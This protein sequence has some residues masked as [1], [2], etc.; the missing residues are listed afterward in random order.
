MN[1]CAGLGSKG[2]SAKASNIKTATCIPLPRKSGNNR[3]AA[4]Q[5]LRRAS[6]EF[7]CR[8]LWSEAGS[9][10]LPPSLESGSAIGEGSMCTKRQL[11]DARLSVISRCITSVKDGT[12]NMK[13]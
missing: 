6:E 2:L 4:V 8:A 5:G 7:S 13:D 9:R 12:Y 3:Q 1:S 10:H 11:G